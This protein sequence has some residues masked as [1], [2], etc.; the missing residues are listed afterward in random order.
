MLMVSDICAGECDAREV[1]DGSERA[2]RALRADP[3]PVS[4]WESSRDATKA[5]LSIRV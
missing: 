5:W 1:G 4:L 3:H 2:H